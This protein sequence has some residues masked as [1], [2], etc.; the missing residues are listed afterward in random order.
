MRKALLT[1]LSLVILT[2]AGT[3]YAVTD[4][5]N[6]YLN[7]ER[8]TGITPG[9]GGTVGTVMQIYN[10]A[11]TTGTS[12]AIITFNTNLAANSTLSWG[13][14]SS[15]ELG[16]IVET[17][18]GTDHTITLTGLSPNTKYYFQ[19]VAKDPTKPFNV[20]NYVGNFL[21]KAVLDL[22]PPSP[23][24]F[25]ATYKPSTKSILLTWVNAVVPDYKLTRIVRSTTFFPLTPDDGLVI[26][27]GTA[28]NYDDFD[29]VP[30]VLYY[31]SAFTQDLGG[32]WS[33]PAVDS[34][35]V[36][37]TGPPK[38]P[39]DKGTTTIF[40]HLPKATTTPPALEN[41]TFMVAQADK[42]QAFKN[43]SR[44]VLNNKDLTDI[45][46]S[47]DG[48]PEVLKT[49]GVS[50]HHPK[51]ESKVFSF[52]L[53]VD[54]N[55]KTYSAK[56]GPL[57]DPGEYKVSIYVLDY[58]YSRLVR[59]DGT[60]VIQGPKP[61]AGLSS[62]DLYTF[63]GAIGLIAGLVQTVL[64][65]TEIT[66]L[67]DLYL[68]ILRF[69]GALLGIIGVR[70]RHKPWGTVYDSVTKRPLDPAFVEV[71]EVTP[72]GQA[73][74]VA[75]A[76]TDLDGR[77]G[78]LLPSGTYRIEAGKTHYEFPSKSLSGK[79][80]DELYDNLYFGETLVTNQGELITRNIPLD[81]IGFDWN[82]FVKNKQTLFRLYSRREKIKTIILDGLYLFGFL[83]TLLATI[84][85]PSII[86]FAILGIYVAVFIFQTYWRSVWKAITVK[87]A[88]NEPYS[89][90]IVRVFLANLNQE[91]KRAVADRFGKFY[92]LVAPGNYYI[93]VDAKVSDGSYRRVYRSELMSLNRGVLEGDIVIGGDAVGAK[94]VSILGGI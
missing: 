87:D 40:D 1:F 28:T 36:P 33:G 78:F 8:S 21:T 14:T 2:V 57:L 62:S 81:P 61:A 66:S 29:V 83:F 50:M 27:E 74:S 18:P 71:K 22:P 26:Y 69:G 17:N 20:A 41:L 39:D 42:V 72:S 47:Y 38:I 80:A 23:L 15:Y 79:H 10:V 90:A 13:I 34:E 64:I 16:S 91:V 68:L 5:I 86:N 54:N 60:F 35:K 11:V 76:I 77:Y 19:I 58:T 4:D 48:L 32:N 63:G 56:I 73:K 92:L 37:D 43:G 93:T 88:N 24:N 44:V 51:D 84:I 3:A 59:L 9:G 85:S 55:F 30:G 75:D 89:F 52:L 46:I 49:I 31:Y 67:Y 7:V 70:R 6:V 82:E 45:Y 53:R 65:T 94:R 25:D 12:T